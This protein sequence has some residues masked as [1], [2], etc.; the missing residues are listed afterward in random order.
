MSSN[1][2]QQDSGQCPV[3]VTEAPSPSSPRVFDY[4][5]NQRHHRIC[6][7][8]WRSIN[9]STLGKDDCRVSRQSK[10]QNVSV[11]YED[12]P[13]IKHHHDSRRL[14]RVASAKESHKTREKLPVRR[15]FSVRGEEAGALHQH[16]QHQHRRRSSHRN[17]QRNHRLSEIRAGGRDRFSS[18]YLHYQEESSSC[19]G[20]LWSPETVTESKYTELDLDGV[21]S[22]PPKEIQRR[23]IVCAVVLTALA[24]LI[25]SVLLVTITLLLTPSRSVM[26]KDLRKENEDIFRI[27]PSTMS[28]YGNVD[29]TSVNQTS[30]VTGPPG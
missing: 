21:S 17:S 20:S 16:Y 23:R 14:R 30:N 10:V 19:S 11:G 4:D 8:H 2:K 18:R 29:S 12:V 28:P 24:I 1:I 15:T 25:S 5:D 22:N 6:S 27:V 9:R 7:R 13:H 3:A 26:D